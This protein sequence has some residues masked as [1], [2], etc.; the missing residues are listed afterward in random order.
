MSLSDNIAAVVT[1]IGTAL[2]SKAD[3][4]TTITAGAGLSGGGDLTTG[5]TLSANFGAAADTVCE[6]DDARLSDARTPLAHTHI[7]ADVTGLQTALDAK[8]A[9]D[10]DA[11]ALWMG[12]T[13]QLPATGTTGTIYVVTP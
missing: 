8:V 9:K 3:K 2:K 10:G 5:R 6:G 13:A 7:V 4:S 1:A 11:T 12:T